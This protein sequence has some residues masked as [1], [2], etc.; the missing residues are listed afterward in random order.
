MINRLIVQV[1]MSEEVS[2]IITISV[3]ELIT[4]SLQIL[5]QFFRFNTF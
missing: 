3:S 2:A 5:K 4:V 1:V